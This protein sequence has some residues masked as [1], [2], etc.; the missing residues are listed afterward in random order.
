MYLYRW[1]RGVQSTPVLRIN[2]FVQENTDRKAR[3]FF[4]IPRHYSILAS[5]IELKKKEN[6]IVTN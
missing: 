3:E 4:T 6:A 1:A 2:R 5:T